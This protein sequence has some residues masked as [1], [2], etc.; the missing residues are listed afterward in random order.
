MNKKILIV[1][2]NLEV[3]RTS[4]GL[5]SNKQ[6]L[7]YKRY[8]KNVEV[9]TST[10]LNKFKQIDGVQYN[11]INTGDVT[12]GLISKI[13]K[14]KAIPVYLRGFNYKDNQIIKLYNQTIIEI[15]NK[16]KKDLVVV[17]STGI[18]HLCSFAM[19]KVDKNLY[20]KY[21][22]F[23]HDPYP[24]RCFPEPYRSKKNIVQDILKR[25]FQKV[26]NKAD[27]ISYP[28]LELKVWMEKYYG[29]KLSK[30]SIIQ[31]HIGLSKSEMR[32]ILI[33]NRKRTTNLNK[34]LNI[35]HTG[36]LIGHRNPKYLFKAFEKLIKEFPESKEIVYLNVIGRVTE[37]WSDLKIPHQNINVV[38]ERI[39]YEESLNIQQKSDVL[40]TLEPI[41][42]I[43]PMMPGKMAD[44]FIFSKPILTLC[45]K[46]SENARLLGYDYPL[47]VTNG[48]IDE[49]YKALKLIYLSYLDSNLD[50]LNVSLKKR[51]QVFP[52]FWINRLNDIL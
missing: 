17:L 24:I 45:S 40:F 34:G 30:K 52:E 38:K 13:P 10:D 15:L 21:L 29:K 50:K 25:K 23:V 9:L 51:E 7:L 35:T 44:Y 5:R 2:E 32:P 43:S 22:Q 48:N 47:T 41:A 6:I 20:S 42:D 27:I 4:S 1:A 3:N 39:S 33:E 36:T 46:K 28:S 16:E 14:I 11:Y 19:L 49:I 8:F 31:H 26:L 18:S 12:R 37:Y